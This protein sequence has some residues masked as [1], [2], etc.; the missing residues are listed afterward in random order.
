MQTHSAAF[1]T[2]MK[3]SQRVEYLR[4]TVGAV[5]FTNSNILSAS[6]SNACTDTKDVKFGSARIGQLNIAFHG[7]SVG[8]N[9]W[10]GK[11]IDLE[12]GLQLA[13]ESVEYIPVGK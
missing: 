2:A 10:R 8:W 9:E 6:Y 12:Y 3:D 11:V 13:D 7:L 1:A 5:P 4:G